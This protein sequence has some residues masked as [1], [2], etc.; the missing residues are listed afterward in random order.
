MVY[1]DETK[2]GVTR[3]PEEA[4]AFGSVEECT[5]HYLSLHAIPKNY[6]Q[7]TSDGTLKFLDVSTKQIKLF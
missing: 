3:K 5:Q 7:F 4:T 1:Q 6:V 2:W